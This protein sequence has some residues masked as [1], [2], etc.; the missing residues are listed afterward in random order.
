M[1]APTPTVA[2]PDLRLLDLTVGYDRHPA[3]HHLQLDVAAGELLAVVGPNGAG[4]S[5]LLRALAGLQAPGAGRVLLDGA[6]LVALAPRERG[7]TLPSMHQ[8]WPRR[9]PPLR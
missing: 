6:D 7:R 4:K 3:V 8:V 2:A 1:R 9:L 5:T